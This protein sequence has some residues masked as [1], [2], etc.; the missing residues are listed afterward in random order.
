MMHPPSRRSNAP[1]KTIGFLV[2]WID[3]AYQNQILDGARDA[4]R[5]HRIQLLCFAGGMLNSELRGGARRNS[6]Y[7]LVGPETVDGLILMSGTIGN[8]IG[9]AALVAYAERFGALPR[10]SIAVELPGMASIVVDNRTGIDS[11]ITHLIKTHDCRR[12]AFVRGP[13]QNLEAELRYDVYRS[14]LLAHG[15]AFDPKLVTSGDFLIE[16]GRQAV[17][18]LYGTRGLLPDAIVTAN[19]QMAVGVLEALTARKVSV[20]NDVAVVGFDDIEEAR[21]TSPPLTTVRQPLYEQGR[22]AVRLL[23]GQVYG[24]PRGEHVTLHT[25]LV[26]RRSCRCFAEQSRISLPA[27]PKRASFE[28]ALVER[29][30]LVLADLARAARGGLGVLGSGWEARLISALTRDLQG[31][32]QTAFPLAVEE[33]LLKLLGQRTDF[34]LFHD[35]LSALRR[36]LLACLEADPG[37]RALAEDLFQHARTLV[38]QIS[39]RAQ[40]QQ[41]LASIRRSGALA[42]AG[43]ALLSSFQMRD[44]STAIAQHL[45]DLGIRSC[46]LVLNAEHPGAAPDLAVAYTEGA[47]FGDFAGARAR[48]NDLPRWLLDAGIANAFYVGPLF[49][50][51]Q[52]L[53]Y[54]LLDLGS[55]EGAVYEA[56]REF[57][58]A[59][60][61]GIA[62][63]T[64]SR[65]TDAPPPPE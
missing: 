58:N 20:P 42:G 43:G 3:G 55:C 35:V 24:G 52:V 16:S 4:A 14:A 44:L 29:R 8:R 19:D 37:R 54:A 23:L 62:L 28:A 56:L 5:D 49:S 45:P 65:Q 61:R 22:E 59:A 64:R 33:A 36:H 25:E 30:Q 6:I 12:I 11:A 21:F 51:Q 40:A 60:V 41:K 2:D 34:N 18:E 26:V 13:E 15:L 1:A 53:G 10:V 50:E 9:D 63:H 32:T 17:E 31:A 27:L 57:L 38:G 39:E 47:P 7:D 48:R 46:F